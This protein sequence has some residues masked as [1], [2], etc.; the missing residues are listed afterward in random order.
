M[1]PPEKLENLPIRDHFRLRGVDGTRMDGLSDGI[2]ALAV[3]VLLIS[4][5]VPSNYQELTQFVFD[6]IPFSICILFVYWIWNSLSNF[7]IR[8]G[9]EDPKTSFLKMCLLFFVLFYVYPLKFLMSWQVKYFSA[10]FSG[11]FGEKYQELNTMIPFSKLSELMVIYG[12]GFILIYIIIYL[13]HRRAYQY[14]EAL[15]LNEREILETQFS[16]RHYFATGSVGV[17]SVF[18]ALVSILL[19]YPLGAMFAGVAYNLIWIFVIIN[20]R[21][22]KKKLAEFGMEA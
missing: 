7:N 4:S 21:H 20:V 19:E 16:M 14:R 3:A 13:L 9:M 6:I 11:D 17:I 18:L 15:Q 10:V 5:S 8:Y 12:V 2:F 22:E 1:L